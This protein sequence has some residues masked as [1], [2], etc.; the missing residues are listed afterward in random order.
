MEARGVRTQVGDE[1]RRIDAV[2]RDLERQAAQR[3]K[4]QVD[5][6]AER[7]EP[8]MCILPELVFSSES[9]RERLLAPP[10]PPIEQS[11]A[12]IEQPVEPLPVPTV[13]LELV[14]LLGEAIVRRREEMVLEDLPVMDE[15]ATAIG[16]MTATISELSAATEDITESVNSVALQKHKEQSLTDT[17][18]RQPQLKKGQAIESDSATEVISSSLDLCDSARSKNQIATAKPTEPPAE[19]KQVTE[20]QRKRRRRRQIYQQYAAKF[21]GKSAYECDRL[22]VEQLMSELLLKR[23]GKRLSDERGRQGR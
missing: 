15:L 4:R 17:K 14:H 10:M 12:L 13:D 1:S 11:P 2:N 21:A 9:E 23:G 22:V 3:E 8:Q 18:L 5:I 16:Q 6:E 7:V 20:Q 19:K